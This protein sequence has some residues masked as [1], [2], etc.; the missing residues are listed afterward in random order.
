MKKIMFSA[1]FCLLTQF[2]FAQDL[3]QYEKKEFT[4]NGQ[5]LLYRIL[6]PEHYEEGKKYRLI[7]FLH[8]SGERGN[9][10][11]S[12]LQ[13]GGSFF[14]TDSIRKNYPAIVIFP[15]C[16]KDSSWTFAQHRFDSATR[17]ISFEFP[18]RDMPVTPQWLVK[19][20]MDSLIQTNHADKNYIYLGGLSLGGFGTYD[21]IERYPDFFAAAFP[22]C[23]AGDTTMASRFAHKVSLWIFQGGADPVVNPAYSRGYYHAL[24]S[25]NTDVKYSEY[26]GVGHNSW[27][28]A[29]AEKDL[30]GWLFS[31]SKK[32]T[33]N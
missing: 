4:R 30:I 15:Q 10:N 18:H 13:H 7:V 31:K 26:P 32:K 6:Y 1:C 33:K 25:M 28:N 23:G 12:Q 16:P 27:D 21:M 20:L 3:S 9:D 29:F 5:T 22:I 19:E 8:G 17:K 11:E 14:L 24:A 2:L